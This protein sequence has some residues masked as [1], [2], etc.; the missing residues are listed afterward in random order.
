MSSTNPEL[1]TTQMQLTRQWL[2][3]VVI[4]LRLCPFAAQPLLE[5]RVR[6]HV[7]NSTT[8]LHLLETLHAELDWLDQQPTAEL[9]TTL[10][11]LPDMLTNFADYN[12]FLDQVDALLSE[13]SWQGKYQVASF[14]PQYC[15]AGVAP[16]A[17]ENLTNRAPYPILH[18]I[19]EDSMAAALAHIERP[20]DIPEQ[21]VRRVTSLRPDEKHQLFPWIFSAS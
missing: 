18:L 2:E 4:G 11:V 12:Q 6:I 13:F 15:F 10:L 21:N 9:E 14:H 1:N 7:C 17:A 20:E 16:E 8:E 5:N 19:R 3:Q